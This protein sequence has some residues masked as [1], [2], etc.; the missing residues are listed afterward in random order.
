MVK[1]YLTNMIAVPEVISS[2]IGV[3]TMAKFATDKLKL[4]PK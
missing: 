1:T 4:S 2:V 3:H